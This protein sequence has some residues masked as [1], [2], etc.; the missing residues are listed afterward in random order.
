MYRKLLSSNK[1]IHYNY[2]II[3][4]IEVGLILCGYEVKSVKQGNVNLN[5][6]IIS[7]NRYT[8]EIYIDNLY[9]KPYRN[10]SSNI[11]HYNPTRQRKLLMH[12]F[13]IHKMLN[14]VK[15]KG[16]T[17]V[18]LEI[19]MTNK[20]IIKLLICLVKGKKIYDK[21]AKIKQRDLMRDINRELNNYYETTSNCFCPSI[22][23]CR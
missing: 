15:D 23:W 21:R 6:C 12:K 3:S 5:D 1:K 13:E 20:K 22:C 14:Q 11:L 10:I 16:K 4:K 19:Y 18:P 9:I 2:D 8:Y 7:I 17:I